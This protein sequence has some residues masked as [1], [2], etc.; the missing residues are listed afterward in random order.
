MIKDRNG[1]DFKLGAKVRNVWRKPPGK[2]YNPDY[3][4]VVVSLNPKRFPLIG[5]DCG[6]EFIRYMPGQDL[7]QF[8]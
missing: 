7:E 1:K 6:V 5:V 3:V 2:P 4:G 8:T